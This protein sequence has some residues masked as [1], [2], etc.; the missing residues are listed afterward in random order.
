MK[1][2]IVDVLLA[3]SFLHVHGVV[4]RNLSPDNILQCHQQEPNLQLSPT[5]SSSEENSEGL[6]KE[7]RGLHRTKYVYKLAD[8]GL[9]Y[10]T[11]EGVDVPFPIGYV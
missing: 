7:Q 10:M 3:L 5:K 1:K 6:D 9:Y 2:V 8:Y 4:H 11:G